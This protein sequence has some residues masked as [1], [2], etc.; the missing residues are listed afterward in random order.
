M[1]LTEELLLGLCTSLLGK[2]ELPYGE[3]T[4]SFKRPWKKLRFME[5]PRKKKGPPKRMD[6]FSSDA[7]GAGWSNH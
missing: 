4:I 5:A 2:D 6:S 1:D 7:G 3:A